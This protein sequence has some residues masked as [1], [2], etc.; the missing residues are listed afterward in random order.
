VSNVASLYRCEVVEFNDEGTS[1]AVCN[2]VAQL[3]VR[4]DKTYRLCGRHAGVFG[5]D[6]EPIAHAETPT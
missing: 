6:V 5:T 4:G 3:Y 1:S 2:A